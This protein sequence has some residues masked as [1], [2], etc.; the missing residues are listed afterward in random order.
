VEEAA[1][2]RHLK[3]V[4]G[5]WEVVVEEAEEA[6]EVEE[7]EAMEVE[8]EEAR[9]LIRGKSGHVRDGEEGEE[10]RPGGEG[11]GVERL[12][13][14]LINPIVSRQIRFS[15]KYDFHLVTNHLLLVARAGHGAVLLAVGG[16]EDGLE[17]LHGGDHLR[18]LAAAEE[19]EA[20]EGGGHRG[21]GPEVSS[22]FDQFSNTNTIL[23]S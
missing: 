18:H 5:C 13:A 15:D 16:G 12:E 14:Y 3:E 11:S 19:A 20:G 1:K 7:E 9:H 4:D 2:I 6:M 23:V 21:P 8:E 22:R 10:Q 17:C